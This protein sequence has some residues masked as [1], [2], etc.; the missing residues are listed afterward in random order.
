MKIYFYILLYSSVLLTGCSNI[1]EKASDFVESK[2]IEGKINELLNSNVE[3]IVTDT[4]EDI[5]FKEEKELKERILKIEDKEITV[6]E[7]I[8]ELLENPQWGSIPGGSKLGK[9]GLDIITVKGGY[10]HYYFPRIIGFISQ[11]DLNVASEDGILTKEQIV[12]GYFANSE[13]KITFA[14]KQ[15]DG[16]YSSITV[17]WIVGS[18]TMATA[19]FNEWNVINNL[20]TGVLF[21]ERFEE[22]DK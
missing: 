6:E 5:A 10:K 7:L 8:A 11:E 1:T 22:T 17:E 3:E 18:T 13:F 19:E 12:G 16:T 9:S 20:A 4:V 15:T 2:N 21:Q 14:D